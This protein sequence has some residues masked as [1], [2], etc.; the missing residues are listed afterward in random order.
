MKNRKRIIVTFLLIVALVLGVG[1]AALTDVLNID[2]NIEVTQDGAEDAFD[3]DVYFSDV[4]S[5][6]AY[7]AWIQQDPDMASFKIT[8]LAGQGDTVTITFTVKNDSDVDAT[9]VASVNS[10]GS[11]DKEYFSCVTSADTTPV[12][13]P[14][15]GTATIDVTVTLLKTPVLAVNEIKSATFTLEYDVS[16]TT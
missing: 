11:S 5:G 9:F 16:S 6:S 14:A 15:G 3:A 4:S 10:T 12:S 7:T 8:G 2:G 1:Y 13:L